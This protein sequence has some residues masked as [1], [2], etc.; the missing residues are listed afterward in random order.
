MSFF[1]SVG[2][3]LT[4]K[5]G[6]FYGGIGSALNKI[7]GLESMT[8]KT[9]KQQMNAMNAQNAYNTKMWN[10]QNEYNSP[11]AQ[12]ARMAEAGIEINPTSYALG[13]GNLSNTAALVGSASGFSGSGSPAGNPISMLMGM[14]QGVQGI[15]ESKARV[16]N[17]EE[18]NHNLHEVTRGTRIQNDINQHDLTI[19]RDTGTPVHQQPSLLNFGGRLASSM[20]TDPE[21]FIRKGISKIGAPLD[22]VAD[23]IPSG[24]FQ[25]I[26]GAVKKYLKK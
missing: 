11:S 22:S 21:G 15:R 10:L 13:T 17:M 26:R 14:A 25:S 20:Y 5:G 24:F 8:D 1:K 19:A 23:A 16:A 2:D 6:S 7:T 9:Y 18:Q 3:T 4:G 12:L